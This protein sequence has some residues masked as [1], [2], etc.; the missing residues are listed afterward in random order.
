MKKDDLSTTMEQPKDLDVKDIH[1]NEV[2]IVGTENPGG[3]RVLKQF[4][5]AED[6]DMEMDMNLLIGT[7]M[8]KCCGVL[9]PDFPV[10]KEEMFYNSE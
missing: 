3:K 2:K 1:G 9:D 6:M 4:W 5:I 7:E 10:V 8:M